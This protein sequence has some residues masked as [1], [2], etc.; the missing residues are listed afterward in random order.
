VHH[1]GLLADAHND[2]ARFE[3][4]VNEVVRT[5]ILQAKELDISP[6]VKASE[7]KYI[8]QLPSQEQNSSSRE[9]KMV[10]NKE[11][12]KGWA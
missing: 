3:I 12:L 1:V 4:V 6:S 11:V 10:V 7:I 9:M 2:V 8:Y 5:D